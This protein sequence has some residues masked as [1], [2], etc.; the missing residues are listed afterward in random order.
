MINSAKAE[1]MSSVLVNMGLASW[2][3]GDEQVRTVAKAS[4]FKVEYGN[5]ALLMQIAV[6]ERPGSIV[7]GA[8]E[9]LMGGDL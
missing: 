5:R 2:F 9:N 6:C 1:S 8:N 3:S 4:A 7:D